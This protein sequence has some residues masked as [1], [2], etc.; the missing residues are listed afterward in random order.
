MPLDTS[1]RRKTMILESKD[2]VIVES[3]KRSKS[4]ER[5]IVPIST[6][7]SGHQSELL[8]NLP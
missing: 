4:H 1:N 5:A 7:S 2:H 8:I 6:C 3:R